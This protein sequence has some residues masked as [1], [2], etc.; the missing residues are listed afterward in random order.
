MASAAG[1]FGDGAGDAAPNSQTRTSGGQGNPSSLQRHRFSKFCAMFCCAETRRPESSNDEEAWSENLSQGP[2]NDGGTPQETALSNPHRPAAVSDESEE[3]LNSNKILESRRAVANEFF[4]TVAS[5]AES[6][7]ICVKDKPE[8]IRR[9][10]EVHSN[11]CFVFKAENI[12][13]VKC[14]NILKKYRSEVS[15][16][17]TRAYIS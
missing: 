10:L 4:R 6:V 9:L 1:I 15:A 14:V 11:K 5:V 13:C 8:K 3:V 16:L 2:G 7:T 17:K 12:Q